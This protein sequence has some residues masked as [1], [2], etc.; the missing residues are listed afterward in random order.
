MLKVLKYDWKSGWSSIRSTLLAAMILAIPAGITMQNNHSAVLGTLWLILMLTLLVL[1]I[2]SIFRNMSSRMFGPEGYLTHTLPVH[3]WE[4][5]LGKA[6]G[7]WIFGI[8]MVVAATACWMLLLFCTADTSALGES[9]LKVIEALPKL[10]MYHFRQLA[11]GFKYLMLG[12]LAFLAMSFLL[13]VQLQFIC[14]AARQFGRFHIAGGIIVF[15]VLLTLE[16]S[17]NQ[18]ASLGFLLFLLFSAACF[19]GSNWL[20]KHRLSI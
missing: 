7:T 12:T 14:I 9:L 16:S 4:L 15:L 20:L 3:T 10:G 19:A 1:T 13:V 5:L 6:A 17:W 18:S 2:S 11:L 8:F